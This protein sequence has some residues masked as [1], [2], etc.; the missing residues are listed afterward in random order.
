MNLNILK[1]KTSCS[2]LTI[3]HRLIPFQIDVLNIR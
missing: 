1:R 2:R 3:N